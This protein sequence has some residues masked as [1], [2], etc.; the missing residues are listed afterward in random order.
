MHLRVA[1]FKVVSKI[2]IILLLG[3][4][5]MDLVQIFSL[6][7]LVDV[8]RLLNFGQGCGTSKLHCW[9]TVS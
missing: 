2:K 9:F 5:Y 1:D 6:S 7:T 3:G 8:D 4:L